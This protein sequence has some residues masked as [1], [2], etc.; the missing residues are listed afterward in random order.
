MRPGQTLVTFALQE[1]NALG[2][3]MTEEL[4]H[5]FAEKGRLLLLLDAFDEVKEAL[6]ED[7]ITELENLLKRH[8]ALRAVVTSRPESGIA[9]SPS[10]RIFR[11]SPLAGREYESVI[12]RMANDAETAEA[13]INGIRK[14][15]AQISPVLTT[16][17][18]V[19]L[20]MVRYKI[21]QSLPE[22]DAAFYNGLFTLLLQRHDKSKGGYVRPRKSGLSD[23]SL[24]DFF[25]ALCFVTRKANEISFSRNQLTVYARQALSIICQEAD[26]DR[27]LEDIID[28]TCLILVDGDECRFIHKSV[29]EYHAALF[30]RD[31]PQESAIAFFSAM[32]DLW[33][34]WSQEL[35]FLSTIDRYRYLKFFHIPQLKRLLQ[36]EGATPN[37]F[38][39]Q[40]QLLDA[41]CGGDKVTCMKN[42]QS[43]SLMSTGKYW[44]IARMINEGSR[45]YAEGIF[46]IF[47]DQI[48]DPSQTN[49]FE[50]SVNQLLSMESSKNQAMSACT[51]LLK[52]LFEELKDSESFVTQ[53][54]GRKSVLQF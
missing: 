40:I 22:N 17:L 1:L 51:D 30:I 15:A 28:I 25:N 29:Q 39:S 35:R 50:F 54:E 49:T 37:E 19:A 8:E 5:F 44:P 48:G 4:F 27:I 18:M 46:L 23:T 21:D 6:R 47:R 32:T 10:L 9:S 14:D 33:S 13:I 52:T 20:L 7:V 43:I 31:Q 38:V 45:V 36:I 53:V 12:R 3:E 41:V 11:L 16:P 26:S 34:R 24:L 2:F 42:G